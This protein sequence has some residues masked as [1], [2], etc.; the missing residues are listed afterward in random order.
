MPSS[1]KQTSLRAAFQKTDHS[2]PITLN[3]D[4]VIAAVQ[5]KLYPATP[6]PKQPIYQVQVHHSA[7][8]LHA[9]LM[10]NSEK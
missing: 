2:L 9:L 4:P 6:H 1:L 8:C 5:K 10:P 7:T 3:N